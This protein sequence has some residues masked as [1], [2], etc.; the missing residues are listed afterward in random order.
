MPNPDPPTVIEE[1]PVAARLQILTY[2]R[3]AIANE[4]M[5]L[6]LD[7]KMPAVKITC[8]LLDK[9]QAADRQ[10]TDVV[11]FQIVAGQLLPPPPPTCTPR[12][13]LDRPKQV[14]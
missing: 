3:L 1:E 8:R 2:L 12:V 13:T 4:N 6:A 14:P 9:C 10:L 7:N 11:D 5:L